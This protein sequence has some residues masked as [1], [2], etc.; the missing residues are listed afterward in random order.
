MKYSRVTEADRIK[1]EL[2]IKQQKSY[3]EIALEIGKHKSTVSRELARNRGKR[4]YRHQQAH[5]LATNR[6]A[7]KHGPYKMN[8]EIC[9]SIKD[10]LEK[11]WS[12]EQISCRL[13]YEGK[14]TV[15]HETIYLYI[16][17]DKE[18]G[19]ELWK[20]LRHGHRVRKRRFPSENRRGTIQNAVPISLRS[21]AANNRSRI[22]HW[23]R[24]TMHGS[25]RKTSVLVFTDR[26]SRFNCFKMLSRRT[27]TNVT[28][29][30][31]KAIGRLPVASITNDRG[32]EFS[33][34][35]RCSKL[36]KTKIYFCDPYSSYQRG[37]N[38]NRIGILRQY[39]PKGTDLR[40]INWRQLK[41]AEIEINNRPMKCL[42]WRTPYE[43]MMG[44]SCTRKL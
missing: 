30:T 35:A 8:K 24:D 34:H 15:S 16:Y 33:D 17:K 2:L 18:N 37:S 21:K 36:I 38:E 11:K 13:K 28:A 12:P 27:A 22:G 42:D 23:E 20:N 5:L 29:A 39:F 4:G 7:S 3:T 9:Q 6:E 19:G 25:D 40:K 43:V 26:K 41:T 31:L 14:P 44:K 10:K 32:Q 1:I